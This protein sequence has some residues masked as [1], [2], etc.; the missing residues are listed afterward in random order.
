MDKYVIHC[1]K[2]TD[3]LVNIHNYLKKI[4]PDLKIWEGVYIDKINDEIIKKY[5]DNLDISQKNN[6]VTLGE[7]GCYLSHHTLLKNI[8]E[9]ELQDTKYTL[10]L[11]DDVVFLKDFKSVIS[12]ELLDSIEFDILYLGGLD[13][14]CRDKN[15]KNEIFTINSV[16]AA[17]TYGY[18]IKNSSAKKLYEL[19]LNN[20][21]TIDILYSTF[22][23]NNTITGLM[24]FPILCTHDIESFF[25]TIHK[26]NFKRSRKKS[27]YCPKFFNNHNNGEEKNFK[28]T[29][30]IEF[31]LKSEKEQQEILK[32]EK[33]QMEKEKEQMEKEKEK[34]EKQNINIKRGR[35][36][37]RIR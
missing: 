10:I 36:K 11:E 15:I 24:I 1:D 12:I 27:N 32:K 13:E 28:N 29:K 17:A 25:T 33:E 5:D 20:P 19:T 16:Y 35:T 3:R 9:K 37:N 18:I 34:R 21:N 4:F 8:K 7:V 23:S 6:F 31:L 14:N 22:V 30:R 26:E 2:H